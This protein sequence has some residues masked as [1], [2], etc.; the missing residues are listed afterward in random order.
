MGSEGARCMA[1]LPD[2]FNAADD[3]LAQNITSGRGDRTA[4]IDC[5]GSLSY[6]ALAERVARM[7]GVWR[8]LGLKPGDRVLLCLLDTRAFPIAFLGALRAG[9]VP[10]PLNTLLTAGDY[11]WML[12]D[13]G[14][15]AVI[16]SSLLADKWI[17]IAARG[18]ATFL[19]SEGGPWPDVETLL[20]DTEPLQESAGTQPE[21]IAF[22]LYTSGSTGRPKAAMHR[23]ASIRLAANLYGLAT[24]GISEHDVVFSVA[25]QFFAYGLGNSMFFPYAAGATVVLHRDRITP[26]AVNT[27][28]PAHGVTVLSGVPT[29]FAAWLRHPDCLTKEAVPHLRMAISAGEALPVHLCEAFRGRFGVDIH[30]GLGSTEMLHIFLSQRPGAIRYG[31]TGRP[32]EGY[33]LRLVGDDGEEVGDGEIGNLHVSGPTSA[34]SYWR[35]PEKSSATFQGEWTVTGDKYVRDADGWYTYAGRGDDML[36]VGGIFVSPMEVEEALSSHPDVVEVA[37]VAAADDAGL[38]KPH[39]FVVARD[40]VARDETLEDELKAHVKSLLAPYKYPRWISFLDEL[41]KTATGKIQR[42]RLR[43]S[44]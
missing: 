17:E 31:C 34:S 1:D 41:P 4:L 5:H 21:D 20:R 16:V 23:H 39:A 2:R 27:L 30:D 37:V 29:F 19:S 22:W 9:V 38:I 11:A 25:K 43:R 35:N 28:L 33:R 14:A 3:L 15:S 40:G 8:A 44:A 24:A 42:F 10:V 6:S 18:S 26:E 36:K 12:K 13:S 32:V 7:A